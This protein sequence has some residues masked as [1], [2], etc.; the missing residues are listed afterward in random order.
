[1]ARTPISDTVAPGGTYERLW[2]VVAVNAA[3]TDA[4][5]TVENGQ[6][7]NAVGWVDIASAAG[8]AVVTIRSTN[9]VASQRT[10]GEPVFA[11]IAGSTRFKANGDAVR[12]RTDGPCTALFVNCALSAGLRNTSA[13]AAEGIA[14]LPSGAAVG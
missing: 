3:D 2:T 9:I 1:G 4:A 7:S 12:R 10:T 13:L 8:A 5:V 11:D 6:R 14:E